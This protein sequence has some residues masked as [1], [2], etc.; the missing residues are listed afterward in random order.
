MPVNPK[1]KLNLKP[2]KPGEVRNPQGINRKRPFTDRMYAKTEQPLA[3]TPEGRKIK[4][5]QPPTEC[6][7]GDAAV[8]RLM[9]EATEAAFQ[10]FGKWPT[11]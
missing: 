7:L 1:S 4:T 10:Q 11:E 6:D 3:L 8:E 2:I 9:I 5:I